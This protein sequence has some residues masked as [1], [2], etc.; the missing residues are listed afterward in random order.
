MYADDIKCDAGRLHSRGLAM[1]N[2]SNGHKAHLVASMQLWTALTGPLQDYMLPHLPPSMLA[3]L[4]CTSKSMR[5]LVDT[6]TGCVASCHVLTWSIASTALN[7]ESRAMIKSLPAA[8]AKR[9]CGSPLACSGETCS[10]GALLDADI[11]CMRLVNEYICRPMRTP[12]TS[13]N[14]IANQQIAPTSA[15]R[16]Q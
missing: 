3:L 9:K 16:D 13:T 15:C 10:Q 14:I 6:G 1:S 5:D 12:D 2:D 11:V 4:R 8:A 7:H